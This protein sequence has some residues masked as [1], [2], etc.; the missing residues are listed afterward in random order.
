[1][2]NPRVFTKYSFYG[3]IKNPWIRKI[4]IEIKYNLDIIKL[5]YNL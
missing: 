4:D 2:E 3:S 5:D 1:M